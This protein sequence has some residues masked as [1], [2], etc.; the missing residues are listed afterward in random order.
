MIIQFYFLFFFA[1]MVSAI[2][3]LDRPS[4]SLQKSNELN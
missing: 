4:A 3:A 1:F 2:H